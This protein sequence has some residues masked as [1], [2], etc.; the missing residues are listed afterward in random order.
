VVPI[1]LAPVTFVTL[2]ALE[3]VRPGRPLPPIRGWGAKGVVCFAIVAFAYV[4]AMPRLAELA[5]GLAPVHAPRDR[6]RRGVRGGRRDLLR[7]STAPCIASCRCGGSTS[8]TTA[9]S[10]SIVAGA[11]YVHPLDLAIQLAVLLVAVVALGLTRDGAA[12]AGYLALAAQLF[13]HANICTPQW[14]GWIIQRPEAHSVHHARG[15]HAY[16]YGALT[17]CDIVLGTFAIPQSS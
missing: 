10:A 17:L 11:G 15:V 14:L 2:L 13:T 3:R 1:V 6:G 7:D 8:C 12:L 9:P 5:D 4:I 16:N